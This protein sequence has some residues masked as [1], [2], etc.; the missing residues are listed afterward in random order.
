MILIYEQKND[1]VS[2][3]LVFMPIRWRGHGVIPLALSLPSDF[4]MDILVRDLSKASK[5]I[6]YIIERRKKFSSETLWS[7]HSIPGL[8]MFRFT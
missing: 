3:S 7:H 4:N 6:K 5:G 1:S 2:R 8:F